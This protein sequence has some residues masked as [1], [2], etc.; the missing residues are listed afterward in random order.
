[1]KMFVCEMVR[2]VFNIAKAIIGFVL[3]VALVCMGQTPD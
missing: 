3:F 2:L 1:M